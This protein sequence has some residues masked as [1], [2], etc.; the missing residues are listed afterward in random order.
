[1]EAETGN[2]HTLGW[3]SPFSLLTLSRLP[4][5]KTISRVSAVTHIWQHP[6]THPKVCLTKML[7]DF[8]SDQSHNEDKYKCWYKKV[9]MDSTLWTRNTRHRLGIPS[10]QHPLSSLHLLFLND[11]SL[12]LYVFNWSAVGMLYAAAHLIPTRIAVIFLLHWGNDNSNLSN[13][14]KFEDLKYNISKSKSQV[15]FENFI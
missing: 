2:A 12:E 13:F 1:M 9:I 14:S 4:A 3:L 10:R 7:G 5:S 15:N 6:Q 8:K 11:Y